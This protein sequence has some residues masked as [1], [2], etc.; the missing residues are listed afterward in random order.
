M[1]SLKLWPELAK[2]SQKKVCPPHSSVAGGWHGTYSLPEEEGRKK[3]SGLGG[4]AEELGSLLLQ[5]WSWE[6]R[7]VTTSPS[8]QSIAPARR[9]SLPP[10][11]A[12]Q[13]DPGERAAAS[14]A[15]P[16][17]INHKASRSYR[18]FASPPQDA[19]LGSYLRCL[20]PEELWLG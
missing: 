2:T 9:T 6:G 20:F 14:L 19:A 11:T 16:Y 10:A 5:P 8:H 15:L 17:P 3:G 4:Y 12:L 13:S 1:L 7:V 18:C